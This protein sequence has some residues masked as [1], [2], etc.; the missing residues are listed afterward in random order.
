[1]KSALAPTRPFDPGQTA[2]LPLDESSKQ[3]A[4]PGTEPLPMTKGKVAKVD[5]KGVRPGAAAMSRQAMGK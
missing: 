4:S 5:D 2:C 1:V 3:P